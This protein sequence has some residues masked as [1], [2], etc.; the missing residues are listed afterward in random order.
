MMRKRRNTLGFGLFVGFSL[1]V[2]AYL[3]SIYWSLP[4]GY[5]FYWDS[6]NVVIDLQPN[7]DMWVT[8]TQKYVFDRTYSNQRYRYLPLDEDG[9]ITDITVRE[10]D[11]LIPTEV[12]TE[13]GNLR[14]RWQHELT[15]PSVHTF[16]LKYRVIRG[17]YFGNVNTWIN[18]KAIFPDRP[19]PVQNAT[20][21]VRLPAALSGKVS[22]F[23]SSGVPAIARQI[24]PQT[25]EF[26]ARRPLSPQQELAIEV[27]FPSGVLDLGDQPKITSENPVF[28]FLSAVAALLSTVSIL[29]PPT[30]G[31][32]CLFWGFGD[33]CSDGGGYDG[34]G[35]GGDGGFDGGGGGG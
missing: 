27:I 34:G 32:R 18:W 2:L 5:P 33:G 13:K 12:K 35:G 1:A 19:A 22:S 26:V 11:R 10:N 16:V 29:L 3:F 15:P 24:N 17:V 20:V 6:I 28:I 31:L 9:E 14:I 25:Y 23:T 21:Q 4:S 30:S 8:E 7:G